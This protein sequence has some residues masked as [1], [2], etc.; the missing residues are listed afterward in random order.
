MIDKAGEMFDSRQM[1]RFAVRQGVSVPLFKKLLELF[2]S[3]KADL[4]YMVSLI[5]TCF[6]VV[7]VNNHP[8]LKEIKIYTIGL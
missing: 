2:V 6:F 7:E 5:T 4:D 8:K 3:R 1:I